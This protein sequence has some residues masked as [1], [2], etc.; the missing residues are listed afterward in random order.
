MAEKNSVAER[1][2]ERVMMN[3][4]REDGLLINCARLDMSPGVHQAI[5]DILT[6]GVDWDLLMKKAIWHRLLLLV[7]YHLRSPDLSML[8]PKP[9]LE[10]MKN[11][12]YHS[13]ARNMVL[14][15][16]LA[17]LLSVFSKQEIPVIV[18]KGAALLESI[19]GDI[20]LRTMGDLA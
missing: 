2:S 9:M 19:Y 20:S 4:S 10:K 16:E 1:P 13:L 5:K 17:R 8:V 3:L 14:Q 7:S 18:L 11:L 6:E 15:D 12:H